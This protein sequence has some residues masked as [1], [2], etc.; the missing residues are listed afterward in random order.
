VRRTTRDDIEFDGTVREYNNALKIVRW[1][2]WN[3]HVGNGIDEVVENFASH[4][5]LLPYDKGAPHIP[6]EF[7]RTFTA[8]TVKH[9]RGGNWQRNVTD[10][11]ICE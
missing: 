1:K 3:N 5:F 8:Q 7:N 11:S 2:P 4:G 9:R 10:G 6:L